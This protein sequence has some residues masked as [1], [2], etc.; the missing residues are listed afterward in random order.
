MLPALKFVNVE[1]S[2]DGAIKIGLTKQGW[3][4]A[5]IENP[6]I[7]NN[8]PQALSPEEV[9]FIV[10]H[11]ADNLPEELEHMTV[12]LKA[13]ED[14][15]Q[16]RE[17]LT[18]VL[19]DYYAQHHSQEMTWTEAVINTMRAGLIS[20]SLEL[21]LVARKKT[22]K[23]VTYSVSERGRECIAGVKYA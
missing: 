18:Q 11:I 19:A 21:G 13:M 7:D 17:E 22:G 4:F 2:P 9:N 10:D 23:N 3:D 16:S 20:R 12:A 1:S 15:K 6:V 8:L 5:M 14:G